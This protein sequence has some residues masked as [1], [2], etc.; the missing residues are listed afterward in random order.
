MKKVAILGC[1]PAGLLCAYACEE[2]GLRF[3]QYSQEV[4]PSFIAGAQYLHRHIEGLTD[5]TPEAELQYVRFG[6]KEGYAQKIYGDAEL[7]T[8]WD[9]FG[10]KVPAWN[11]RDVYAHLWLMYGGDDVAALRVDHRVVM[12]LCRSYT[13]VFSTVP[14]I[15]IQDGQHANETVYVELDQGTAQENTI[16]YNGQGDAAWYRASNIFGHRSIEYP[17]R[18]AN[19]V[20][21]GAKKITK[22]VWFRPYSL[23]PDN[24]FFFGRYGKWEKGVLVD[25]AYA[26]A[27]TIAEGIVDA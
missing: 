5:S 4:A 15:S 13:A 7:P 16:V 14:R 11:L 27:R 19:V 6:T 8:S 24:L 2:A 10:D 9:L 1:G 17:G 21:E 26:E 12:E 3:R 18:M 25:H 23:G 22:P 20:L